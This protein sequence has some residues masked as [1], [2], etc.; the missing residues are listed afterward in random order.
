MGTIG[1]RNKEGA[2]GFC[3]ESCEMFDSLNYMCLIRLKKKKNLNFLP[4][5]EEAVTQVCQERGCLAISVDCIVTLVLTVFRR[6]PM[7]ALQLFYFITIPEGGGLWEGL[8]S[9]GE[10]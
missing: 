4:Q 6:D 7:L 5:K 8:C 3:D 9:T 10:Y 2:V 1:T